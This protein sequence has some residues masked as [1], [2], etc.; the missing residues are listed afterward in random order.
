MRQMEE[1]LDKLSVSLTGEELEV[2]DKL[3][4]HAMK[5]EIEVFASQRVVQP[6]VVP[7]I[8]MWGTTNQLL[9]FSDFDL[10]CTTVD[11][12]AMLAEVA[13]LTVPRADQSGPDDLLTHR[14]SLNLRNSWEDLSAK[15]TEEHETIMGNIRMLDKGKGDYVSNRTF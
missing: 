12:S 10:T 8:R 4:S 14:S 2:I 1:L 5:L 11:S 7:L 6:V 13:I 9:I 15:Y 3:Y